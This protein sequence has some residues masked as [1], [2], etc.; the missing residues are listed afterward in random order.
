MAT[1]LLILGCLWYYGTTLAGERV[2]LADFPPDVYVQRL[3]E[4]RTHELHALAPLPPRPAPTDDFRKRSDHAATLIHKGDLTP[5]IEILEAIEKEKP[6]EYIVAVNLGTAYELAGDN[7]RALRWIREGLQRNPNSHYGTEWLHV[8]I[9]ESKI[10]LAKDPAWL[11]TNS[12][13]GLDFGRDLAPTM[14]TSWP[15][16]KDAAATLHALEYQLSERLGFVKA[17]DPLTGSLIADLGHLN[18]LTRAVGYGPPLYALAIRYQAP[19]A[20]FLA[21]R[22]AHV[23]AIRPP[24]D[25]RLE[26]GAAALALSAVAAALVL[27]RRRRA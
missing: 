25:R 4:G 10:A 16:G 5:A 19:D 12:V 18:V 23:G 6:G 20:D 11:K 21:R 3:S 9:L 13:L 2:E 26:W 8:R 7:D 17:P 14:P 24:V 27:H 1:R 15:A 22:S